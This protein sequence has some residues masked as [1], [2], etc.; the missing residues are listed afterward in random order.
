M[1]SNNDNAYM[2]G[3]AA[4]LTAGILSS[5][6]KPPSLSPEV[7][8]VKTFQDVWCLLTNNIFRELGDVEEMKIDD[9]KDI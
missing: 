6:E 5:Q 4:I 2:N 1:D 9:R 8:A 3:I 7:W